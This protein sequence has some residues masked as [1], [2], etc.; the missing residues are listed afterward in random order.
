MRAA[1]QLRGRLLLSG[2]NYAF[3]EQELPA[4]LLSR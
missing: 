2:D 3:N 4:R 1:D